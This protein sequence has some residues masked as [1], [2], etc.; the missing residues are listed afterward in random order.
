MKNASHHEQAPRWRATLGVVEMQDH[1]IFH[2]ICPILNRDAL[3][4]SSTSFARFGAVRLRCKHPSGLT[5]LYINVRHQS[6]GIGRSCTSQC[7][8]NANIA[9]LSIGIVS[10]AMLQSKLDIPRYWLYGLDFHSKA[11]P[12]LRHRVTWK[13][14][15]Y[16]IFNQSN[17]H[18]ILGSHHAPDLDVRSK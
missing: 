10:I 5:P 18:T 9:I 11:L 6:R 7:S 14:L 8:E 15:Q 17:L 12:F 1:G 16:S 4:W 2:R 3:I 13:A